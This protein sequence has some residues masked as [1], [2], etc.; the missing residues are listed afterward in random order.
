MILT[1]CTDVIF[2]LLESVIFHLVAN[3][4]IVHIFPVM[5]IVF[6][7][8]FYIEINF[9]QYLSLL[10]CLIFEIPNLADQTNLLNNGLAKI[11]KCCISLKLLS[12][13]CHQQYIF[14]CYNTS[15]TI[16][17]SSMTGSDWI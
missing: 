5:N 2:P 14:F 7:N 16:R 3:F 4:I 10:V 12:M 8:V 17:Y 15:L 13:S 6:K 11:L 1:D 9:V